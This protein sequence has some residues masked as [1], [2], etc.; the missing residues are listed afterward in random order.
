[1]RFFRTTKISG[2]F[3]WLLAL[4]VLLRSFIAPGY[5]LF[6]SADQGLGIIFCNGPVSIEG[7]MNHSGH[8]HDADDQTS[9]TEKHLSPVCSQWSTSSLLVFNT[10]FEPVVFEKSNTENVVV[11]TTSYF[12]QYSFNIR[13]IRG[14]PVIS[15]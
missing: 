4:A 2:P 1:M 11:Y 8:H 15:A 5:M 10:V 12:K 13:V 6:L 7:H 14:P 3:P 9:H